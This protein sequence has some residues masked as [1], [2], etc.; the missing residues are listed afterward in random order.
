MT[1]RRG[2]ALPELLI[3]VLLLAIVGGAISEGLRRQQ[4]VFRSI[5][6]LTSVRGDAHD[7]AE[8]LVADLSAA[9]PLDTLPLALDSAV[10]FYSLIGASVS[11]DSAPEYQIAMPPEKL[12]SGIRLTTLLASP[13]SGDVLLVFNH[14]SAA[15]AGEPRWERHAVAAVSSAPSTTVCP[16]STGFTSAADVNTPAYVITLSGAVSGAIGRG[17]PVRILRRTR[18]SLYR[19]SDS[20]W[21]LGQRRCSPLGAPACGAIQ[22]VSGPYMA[23]AGSGGQSGIGLRYFDGAALP[24][25]SSGGTT[26][27]ALVEVIVRTRT[28]IPVRP[29]GARSAAYIDS[30]SLSVALRNRD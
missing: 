25:W 4:Q 13:D 14:D 29:G 15:T 16:P 5:A 17:A 18:Y 12:R 8:V 3:S 26:R 22:P 20:R 28:P 1:A 24:V 10:E 7:A 6:L 19:A 23:Y 30:T 2:F 21:Y 11:C 9:S 27:V